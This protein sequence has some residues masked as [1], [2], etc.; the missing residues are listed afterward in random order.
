MMNT[1]GNPWSIVVP[2]IANFES[3]DPMSLIS[4]VRAG[5][6]GSALAK[7]AEIYQLPKSEMYNILDISAKTG[8]RVAGKKLNRDISDHLIQMVKVFYRT[9]EVFKSLD[10]SIQWLKSPCY[11]LGNQA[12]VKLLDTVEG[13]ELVMNTLGCIE[14]GVFS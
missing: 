11:A 6:P 14:Y 5:L 9:Y 4:L 8:Q 2:D 7:V 3:P 13:A 10:K 1:C 12:P